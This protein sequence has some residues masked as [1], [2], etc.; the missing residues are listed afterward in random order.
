[1]KACLLK[2]IRNEIL[3]TLIHLN[4]ACIRK[5]QITA[6]KIAIFT[7]NHGENIFMSCVRN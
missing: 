2:L 5:N 4:L 7:I 3:N 1:M 6:I